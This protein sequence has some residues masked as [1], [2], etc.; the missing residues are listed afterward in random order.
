MNKVNISSTVSAEVEVFDEGNYT[1][2]LAMSPVS[3]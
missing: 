3:S 2:L 1:V